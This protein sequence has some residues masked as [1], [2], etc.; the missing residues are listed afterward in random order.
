MLDCNFKIDILMATYNGEKYIGKQIDSILR[1]TYDNWNLLIRDDGSTDA[2]TSIISEYKRRNPEK[3]VIIEDD[4]GNLGVT[5]NFKRLLL[6]SQSDYVM[7]CDQDDIWDSSKVYQEINMMKEKEKEFGLIPILVFSDLKGIDGND[8]ILFE[9]FR[10]KNGFSSDSC[11][12]SRML[13]ENVATGC[14]ML[15]NCP[16][17]KL[18]YNIPDA[19]RVHDHWAILICLL[20]EGQA[21]YL[22]QATVLYRQHEGNVIGDNSTSALTKICKILSFRKYREGKERT[23]AYYRKIEEQINLLYQQNFSPE[24]RT[25]K[26]SIKLC[27]TLANIWK[28]TCWK[29]ITI[30]KRNNCFQNS[31]YTN[32]LMLCYYFRWGKQANK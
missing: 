22:N 24:E 26:E 30:L 11:R 1:Q 23:I 5:G 13:Y 9:S 4:E 29:R 19:V 32:M 25:E 6:S 31:F 17:K 21:V 10:K 20:N 8:K 18:L 7:F 14:T 15:I 28:Q 2:T 27:F 12:L 16:L 3:I